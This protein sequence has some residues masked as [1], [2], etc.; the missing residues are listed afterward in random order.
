MAKT[1]IFIQKQEQ[2]HQALYIIRDQVNNL[3]IVTNLQLTIICTIALQV[4]TV[5]P[6]LR[7]DHDRAV[8]FMTSHKENPYQRLAQNNDR[9]SLPKL[10]SC[11][12]QWLAAVDLKAE[13]AEVK[14]KQ[15]KFLSCCLV[16]GSAANFVDLW[17]MFAPGLHP[18]VRDHYDS[19][20][21]SLKR[22]RWGPSSDQA[23]ET[24]LT[25]APVLKMSAMSIRKACSAVSSVLMLQE[26][27]NAMAQAQRQLQLPL[28]K[29]NGHQYKE[30]VVESIVQGRELFGKWLQQLLRSRIR[31]GVCNCCMACVLMQQEVERY[32]KGYSAHDASPLKIE[33]ESIT[34][35][36]TIRM[37]QATN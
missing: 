5:S 30:F 37:E 2:L 10:Y 1:C 20:V 9:F 19:L 23:H 33:D 6:T 17:D 3:T 25:I 28:I 4:V 24:F 12:K 35:D 32:L 29:K 14:T 18:S 31:K 26:V 11:L 8:L 21:H 16:I 7:K 27:N 36:H 15:E 22:L 34:N 13:E